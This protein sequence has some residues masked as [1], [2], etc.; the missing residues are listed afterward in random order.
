VASDSQTGPATTRVVR[1]RRLDRLA[2]LAADWDRLARGVPFR[3]WAWLSTWWR[4]YGPGP[5]RGGAAPSARLFVLGVFDPAG[6]LLGVAPWYA[7]SSPSQGRVLRFLGSGEV[8]SDYLSVLC[9]PQAEDRVAA[10]LADWLTRAHRAESA[11]CPGCPSANAVPSTG[12]Q[13]A[14]ATRRHPDHWDLLVLAGVDARDAAVGR[15]AE[16]LKMRGNT[17]H[18]RAGPNCWRVRLPARWEQYLAGLSKDH[19][20]QVRRTER[21]LFASGRV[22]EH[23]V[24]RLEDLPR[25]WDVLVGL[26]Q[27]RWQ[28]L[29]QPGCFA[30]SRFAAFHREV[31]P[32]LLRGGQLRLDWLALDGRPVAAEYQLAGSGVVYAYQAGVSPDALR[33]SPGRLSTITM[34]RRA[35][36]EGCRAVDFLRGD[37]PYKAHWR[38]EPR[39]SVEFRVVAARAA[40]QLRHGIW[41]AGT[42]VKDWIKSG[43]RGAAEQK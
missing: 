33:Y 32:W 8:C 23:R 25:A 37:E 19:R 41:R 2:P 7:E 14:R 35:I 40:A 16:Q 10:A 31:M 13:A 6:R 36:E 17:V 9:E 27:R 38:A 24:E 20:K 12:G 18:R 3:S 15:L 4:H 22:V 42:A 5:G 39:A 1:F 43:L 11:G 21:M 29:G 34:L 30:S 28:S 26:H